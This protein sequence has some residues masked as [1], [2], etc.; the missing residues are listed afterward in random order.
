MS[1][2]SVGVPPV[3]C[4]RICFAYGVVR[5]AERAADGVAQQLAARARRKRGSAPRRSASAGSPTTGVPP[6]S[7]PCASIG[8]PSAYVRA[9]APDARRTLERRGRCRPSCA[10]QRRTTGWRPIEAASALP[11]GAVGAAMLSGVPIGP[12]RRRRRAQQVLED[13]LRRARV[14]DDRPG[15]DVMVRK[16]PRPRKPRARVGRVR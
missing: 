10:W 12:A 5:V 9:E 13:P 3:H 8:V 7:A 2:R 4:V 15:T 6:G 1:A 16:P 11:V 14:G